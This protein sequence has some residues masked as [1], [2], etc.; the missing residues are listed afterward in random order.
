VVRSIDIGEERGDLPLLDHEVGECV[1]L[2]LGGQAELVQQVHD[3]LV[4][5]PPRQVVDV[6]ADVPQAAGLTIDVGEPRLGRND[7]AKT[8]V[9]HDPLLLRWCLAH[10]PIRIQAW[11]FIVSR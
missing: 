9:R 1:E 7:L 8:L 11:R 10:H 2:G 4:G 6:V 5:R 3:L